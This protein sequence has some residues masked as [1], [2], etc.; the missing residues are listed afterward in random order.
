MPEGAATQTANGPWPPNGPTPTAASSTW[1]GGVTG[2]DEEDDD[3]ECDDEEHGDEQCEEEEM[4][5][6]DTDADVVELFMPDDG[7]GMLPDYYSANG[8]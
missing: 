7:D 2:A 6:D 4:I 5:E 3:E 8:S 1:N